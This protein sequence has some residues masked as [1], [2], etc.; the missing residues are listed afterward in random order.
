MVKLRRSNTVKILSTFLVA[1]LLLCSLS[2]S[3]VVDN[4]S[5]STLSDLQSKY[6]KL[7]KELEA[8]KK[9]Y[10]N[11]QNTIANK[12]AYIVYLNNQI[13]LI[14]EQMY[15]L[16]EQLR[17]LAVKIK[18]LEFSIDT[19]NEKITTLQMQ[20]TDNEAEIANKRIEIDELYKLFKE[21]V[22]SMYMEGQ[23]SDIQILLSAGS[24]SEY[25]TISG[26][27]SLI[28]RHDSE[29]LDR[30]T[31]EINELNI[32][33]S[34][35]EIEKGQVD[36]SQAKLV[37]EK[38]ELETQK[39]ENEDLKLSLEAK[40]ADFEVQKAEAKKTIASLSGG[41]SSSLGEISATQK[42]L[43]KLEEE[44]QKE[45][46]A[47]KDLVPEN[48]QYP[49]SSKDF[50]WPVPGYYNSVS[51]HFGPR[52]G[53]THGGI[54]I[55][56]YNIYGKDIIAAR[57]GT[58]I[59]VTYNW[60]LGNYVMISHGNGYVTLYAHMSAVTTKVGAVVNQGTV[61]GKIGSTGDS[62][63]PHLHFEIRING[64]KVDPYPYII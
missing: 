40:T 63:G 26:Y 16:E 9:Q 30:L 12:E 4:T 62:T 15:I 38:E 24:F 47:G 36:E 11:A 21:R 34:R 33:E 35:L 29:M 50:V 46:E 55:A 49:P 57:A 43:E 45:I 18:E 20:I 3:N 60:S 22:R 2:F 59:T 5:A 1:V 39:K 41:L 48:P 27:M 64:T 13:D 37:S 7:E 52:W 42:E 10:S 58:V 54:D 19:I 44:I 17:D 8:L 31:E 51:S 23:V 61:I 32:L 56:G 6:D 53:R 28:A 25:L 14:D